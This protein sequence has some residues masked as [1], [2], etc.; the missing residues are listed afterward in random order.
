M[1]TKLCLSA[2]LALVVAVWTTDAR[3]GDCDALKLCF[4]DSLGNGTGVPIKWNLSCP[5]KYKINVLQL[6]A[7]A[8]NSAISA[9]QKA[10]AAYE[11]SCTELKFQYAGA[12]NSQSDEKGAILVV[13]GDNTKK[14]GSWIYGTSAYYSGMDYKSFQTG[15]ITKAWLAL[16]SGDYGWS[17]GGK[18]VSPPHSGSKSHIDVQTALM[19]M[20]PQALGYWVSKDFTKPELPIGYDTQLSS[21]CAENM[22]GAKYIYFKAGTGCT[23][24]KKP[25]FCTKSGTTPDMGAT[26]DGFFLDMGKP[27]CGSAPAV[28]GPKVTPTADTGGSTTPDSAPKQ[29]NQQSDCAAD[30]ICSIDGLC[31]KKGGGESED[32]GC[33]RVS[34][35]RG[36]GWPLLLVLA[37]GG[38]LMFLRR[39]KY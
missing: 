19:W 13:F 36:A 30:E 2:V 7:S 27:D 12:S 10:F 38:M 11:L 3:A 28:D 8:R 31:L 32:D 35:G 1:R 16:N 21:L 24:P 39:R 23:R 26:A 20:I 22:T 9:V 6:A 5:I 14:A 18:E 25:A 37:I 33:C 4:K 17:V 29:C 15:Q 34:H